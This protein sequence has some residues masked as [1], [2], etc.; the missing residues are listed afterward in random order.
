MEIE[1]V[2]D[3]FSRLTGLAPDECTALRF[4]CEAAASQVRSMRKDQKKQHHCEKYDYAA[5]ALA[6]YRFVLWSLTNG[7]GSEIRVGDISM[8]ENSKQRLDA[9][10]KL[11]R[12]AFI[13]AGLTD[14]GSG[15]VFRRI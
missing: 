10:E 6:Y 1:K 7:D 14:A 12:E 9:A 4:M 2:M 11:C 5:A 8:R 13:D 15:F 3:L